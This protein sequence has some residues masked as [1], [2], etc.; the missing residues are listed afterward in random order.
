MKG[1]VVSSAGSEKT[2]LSPSS[3][4]L[5]AARESVSRLATELSYTVSP[6]E[7]TRL[8][9]SWHCERHTSQQENER[10][11]GWHDIAFAPGKA[12]PPLL[13]MAEAWS[14]GATRFIEKAPRCRIITFCFL[15]ILVS[16][17]EDEN[18]RMTASWETYICRITSTY[19]SH[20]TPKYVFTNVFLENA[21][22]ILQEN[23]QTDNSKGSSYFSC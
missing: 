7:K 1:T 23:L 12:S 16:Q 20:T 4:C 19:C 9:L 10:T 3:S 22:E 17:G 21:I 2:I 18:K 13:P 15:L 6:L 8:P 11:I 14:F 5:R